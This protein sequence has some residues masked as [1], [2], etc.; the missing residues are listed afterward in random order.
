MFAPT[1]R[2]CAA[3]GFWKKTSEHFARQ[4]RF[5]MCLLMHEDR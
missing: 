5:G 2:R 3:P 1:L 4:A